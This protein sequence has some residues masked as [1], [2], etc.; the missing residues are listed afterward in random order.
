MKENSALRS[1][2]LT[3][4]KENSFLCVETTTQEEQFTELERQLEVTE[5]EKSSLR[6][7]PAT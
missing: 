7:K 6:A 1:E 2:P 5:K 3:L 4:K